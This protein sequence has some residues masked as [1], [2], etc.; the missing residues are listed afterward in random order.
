MYRPVI[1]AHFS[2]SQV[3]RPSTGIGHFNLD[4]VAG[5]HLSTNSFPFVVSDKVGWERHAAMLIIVHDPVL[6]I[7]HPHCMDTSPS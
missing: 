5:R 4:M 2:V 6:A 3:P 7:R 1:E